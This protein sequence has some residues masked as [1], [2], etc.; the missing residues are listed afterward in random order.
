MHISESAFVNAVA[1]CCP[2]LSLNTS[3][4]FPY[5]EDMLF[6]A[7]ELGYEFDSEDFIERVIE[8]AKELQ[9][10]DE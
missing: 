8:R 4:V 7:E 10:Y 9:N 5:V 6:L 1:K 2:S 3:K